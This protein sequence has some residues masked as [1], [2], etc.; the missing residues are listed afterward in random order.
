MA[1]RAP[2]AHARSSE[3]YPRTAG[4]TRSATQVFKDDRDGPRH[5]WQVAQAAQRRWRTPADRLGGKPYRPGTL[6]HVAAEL[7]AMGAWT[8][9]P[10][11]DVLA[12]ELVKPSDTL[13]HYAHRHYG[14]ASL[15]P[16]IFEANIDTLDDP[17]E[18]FPGQEIRIP[19]RPDERVQTI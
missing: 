1:R 2:A 13:S 19:R 17:D 18:I 8:F 6:E 14:D 11:K 10:T 3:R 5:V 16:F 12:V 9:V 15:W 7:D 4:V